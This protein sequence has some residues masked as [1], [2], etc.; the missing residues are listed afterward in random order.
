ME[1]HTPIPWKL[2]KHNSGLGVRIYHETR[3]FGQDMQ[4][5]GS[6]GEANASFIVKAVNSHE[7]LV[8][9]CK[10]ALNWI[11]EGHQKFD[12]IHTRMMIEEALKQSEGV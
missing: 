10:Y 7:A 11:N 3:L 2:E 8:E 6:Q 9:A 5:I 12:E 4:F 1:K